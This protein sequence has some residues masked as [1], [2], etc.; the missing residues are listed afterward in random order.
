[1]PYH[2]QK[3]KDTS[4]SFFLARKEDILNNNFGCWRGRRRLKVRHIPTG[5]VFP[6][7]NPKCGYNIFCRFK[8][9]LCDTVSALKIFL[10]RAINVLI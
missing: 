10:K 1:M 8:L 4:I 9:F 6:Q 7:S 3:D 5:L 2:I